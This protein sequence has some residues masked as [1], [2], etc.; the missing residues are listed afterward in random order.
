[1][2]YFRIILVFIFLAILKT[3]FSQT[4]LS[5]AISSNTTWAA[6]GNPYDVTADVTVNSGVTLSI[7][8]GVIVRFTNGTGMFINGTI[9]AIG[10]EDSM[11]YFTTINFVPTFGSWNNI[12]FNPSSA[13]YNYLTETGCILEYCVVEYGGSPA[14][15]FFPGTHAV[16]IDDA[17]PYI[18]ESVFQQNA[19]ALGL[20]L[21][22]GDV[23]I[24]NS[25]FLDNYGMGGIFNSTIY[26]YET[27]MDSLI[28]NCNLFYNN[29]WGGD[30]ALFN[31]H[32]LITNNMF[33]KNQNSG[34]SE[35]YCSKNTSFVKNHLIDN[36]ENCGQL[37]FNSG[38]ANY[39]TI[40]RNKNQGCLQTV[41]N[42]DSL[43]NFNFNNLY[44]NYDVLTGNYY[45]YLNSVIVTPTYP[46]MN[47][48]NN[49]WGITN[50]SDIDSLIFDFSD[51]ATK[52]VVD[53]S[54]FLNS[55]DT[56]APVTP[57]R[58]LIKTDL[59]GGNIQLNWT[60][61]PEVDLAGY[62]VYYGNPTG[63][64]F[65]NF[66]D[67]GNVNSYILSGVNY[68]DTIAVSAYDTQADDSLDQ[69]QCHES[70]FTNSSAPSPDVGII[71][72]NSSENDLSI[73]PNPFSDETIIKSDVI[74]VD[75]TLI[76]FNAFGQEVNRITNIS[77][78][79]I[80]LERNSLSAGFYFI[81]LSQDGKTISTNKVVVTN[82]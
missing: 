44:G 58:D 38:V 24:T 9:R 11:I 8:P 20:W 4:L 43:S 52:C 81:Q 62:K 10:E 64:S 42:G 28:V 25:T 37:L 47:A 18:N 34:G 69:C 75:A 48:E 27:G 49:W 61:N 56:I 12:V 70:W 17:A 14:G 39:N 23:H 19:A 5:G 74:F 35:I 66:I 15:P 51:N 68:S 6:S 82:N 1:M 13:P 63:Y 22:S 65:S 40:T 50:T 16:A 79:T 46:I 30:A 77:G 73:Y 7:E 78:Q 41:V 26:Y 45:E 3:S 29:G 54:P 2:K 31:G 72:S 67:V 80:T 53:Y 32:S 60:P 76:I 55:P 71:E 33:I 59:G 21:I 36:V 57:V